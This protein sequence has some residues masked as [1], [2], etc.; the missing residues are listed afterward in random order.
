MGV[1]LM[2][3]ADALEGRIDRKLRMEAPLRP[4]GGAYNYL[5]LSST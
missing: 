1:G 3:T 5:L 2:K 4:D